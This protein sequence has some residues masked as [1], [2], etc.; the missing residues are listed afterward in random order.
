MHVYPFY[1]LPGKTLYPRVLS[2]RLYPDVT[3]RFTGYL[4]GEQEQGT[5]HPSL[6]L[7]PKVATSQHKRP[8]SKDLTLKIKSGNS[9]NGDIELS[10]IVPIQRLSAW[11]WHLVH[12]SKAVIP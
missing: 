3:A 4:P 1:S 10:T 6:R 12:G 9:I 11:L 8:H 5:T 2:M 7:A